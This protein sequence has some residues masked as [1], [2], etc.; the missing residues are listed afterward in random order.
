MRNL[1][2]FK[3]NINGR[4]SQLIKGNRPVVRSQ[5]LKALVLVGV[6]AILAVAANAQSATQS[7]GRWAGR[8]QAAASNT[9]QTSSATSAHPEAGAVRAEDRGQINEGSVSTATTKPTIVG[10]WVLTVQVPDNE[11]PFDSF[12]ALWSLTGDGI[13]ISS[14][15]G[16][17]TPVPFPTTSSAYGAWTQTSKRQYAASF[18]AI[19][20]DVQ[21]GENMGSINLNQSITL[22]ESGLEWSGPFQAKVLDPDGNLIVVLNGSVSASRVTVQPLQ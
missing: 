17:V 12:K 16:D 10:S 4:L 15:Q 11:P 20:Y 14:A 21:T 19:L 5:L 18:V 22:S 3:I 6:V 8:I 1:N 13:L 7:R 9:I 2:T